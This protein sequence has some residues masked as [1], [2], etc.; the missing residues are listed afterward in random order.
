MLAYLG[1]YAWWLAGAAFLVVLA[2]LVFRAN[3]ARYQRVTGYVYEVSLLKTLAFL[4]V[5]V[6][7][8]AL[9]WWVSA[10]CFAPGLWRNVAWMVA[11]SVL[12]NT[13]ARAGMA[14]AGRVIERWFH[15]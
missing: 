11:L 12:T 3:V 6:G 7:T 8:A 1:A 4:A 14:L 2:A 9:A 13:L 10:L 15:L 5:F